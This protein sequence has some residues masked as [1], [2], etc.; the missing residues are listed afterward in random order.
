M[1]QHSRVQIG[2]V[3]SL[4]ERDGTGNMDEY[5]KSAGK[6]N[7]TR[8]TGKNSDFGYS[9]EKLGKQEKKA[10]RKKKECYRSDNN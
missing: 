1:E 10:K 5:T 2:N 9:R 7:K 4:D 3:P 6:S 8:R